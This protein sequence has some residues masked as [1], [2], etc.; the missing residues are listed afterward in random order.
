MN[1]GLLS[2]FAIV[3]MT[4]FM[5]CHTPTELPNGGIIPGVNIP[6][7]PPSLTNEWQEASNTVFVVIKRDLFALA[8]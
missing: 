7:R 2:L 5:G 8:I 4:S 3:L 1:K 6:I